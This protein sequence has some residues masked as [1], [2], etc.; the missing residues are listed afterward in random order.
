MTFIPVS[1]EKYN[2]LETKYNDLL[3][4][5]EEKEKEASNLQASVTSLTTEIEDLKNQ[6]ID[7]EKIGQL[8]TQLDE[9]NQN[10]QT[11]QTELQ[12]ANDELANVKAQLETANDTVT[13][14]TDIITSVKHPSIENAESITDKTQAAIDLLM[15]K[16]NVVGAE[17]TE[18]PTKTKSP[19]GVDWETLNKLPHMQDED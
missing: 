15:K 12:S 8:Q 18:D 11:A 1:R 6:G 3:T 5:F 2:D 4:S 7:P 9:A 13:K 14:I 16:P 19:D 17:S 10:L